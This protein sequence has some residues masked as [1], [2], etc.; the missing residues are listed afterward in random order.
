MILESNYK[1]L[2]RDKTLLDIKLSQL[3]SEQSRLKF[4]LDLTDVD[5]N[6]LIQD[7]V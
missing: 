6:V 7:Y 2:Q 5:E 4:K 1:K 3:E